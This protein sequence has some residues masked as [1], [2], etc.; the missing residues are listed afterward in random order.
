MEPISPQILNRYIS[1][2]LK[3]EKDINALIVYDETNP[4]SLYTSDLMALS[5][6]GFWPRMVSLL[7]QLALKLKAGD[8]GGHPVS[9]R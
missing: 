9:W 3:A 5:I 7:W 4:A 8:W 2:N 6:Q 1:K